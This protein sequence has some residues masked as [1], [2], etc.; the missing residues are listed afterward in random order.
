MSKKS[1]IPSAWDDDWETQAD[2]WESAPPSKS[3]VIEEEPKISKAERLAKHAEINKKIWESAETPGGLSE[4]FPFLPPNLAKP[5]PLATPYKA[6]LTLLSRK[7]APR[8]IT[9]I[10]PRTGKTITIEAEEEEEVIVTGPTAEEL[11]EKTQREREEKQKKYDEARARILGTNSAPRSNSG[12]GR[13]GSGSNSPRNGTPPLQGRG[14]GRGNDIRRPDSRPDSRSGQ[15]ELFDPNY[16]PKPG[17]ITTQKTSR[18]GEGS[19][20]NSGT[21]TPISRE[22]EQVIRAP[23]GPDATGKGFGFANRGG[24]MS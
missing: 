2:A 8:T 21:S 4:E 12:N 22:N 7:P 23:R 9:K 17:S 19:R 5:V 1:A 11:R 15:K 16:T 6:P 13:G 20:S 14:R 3:K 18:N 24:K 10:D